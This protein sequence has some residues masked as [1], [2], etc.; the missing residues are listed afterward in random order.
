MKRFILMGGF[1]MLLFIVG[2]GLSQA[3][4]Y[5]SYSGFV[6]DEKPVLPSQEIHPQI[7]FS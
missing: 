7:W 2:F 5:D 1:L 4:N 3:A 6:T